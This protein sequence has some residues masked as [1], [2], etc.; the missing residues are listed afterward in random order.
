MPDRDDH[1][2]QAARNLQFYNSFDRINFSEWAVTVLFYAALQYVDAFLATR[3]IHPMKHDIRD[4]LINRLAELKPI[5]S[6]YSFMKSHSR[7]ARY[8][9]PT[10]FTDQEVRDLELVHLDAIRQALQ[11]YLS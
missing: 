3:Q 7:T 2:A 4:R 5:Y 6:H 11:P 1:L 8:A 9:P 10:N